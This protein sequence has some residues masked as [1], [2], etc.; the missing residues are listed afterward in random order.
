MKKTSRILSILL[1]LLM[2]F[3][4]PITAFAAG[5]NPLT[6]ESAKVGDV[7][8]ENAKIPAGSD[9]LLTFSNNVTDASVLADNIDKIKVR[10]E[11][12]DEA[13]STVSTGTEKTEFIVTLGDLSKGSYKLTIG[14]GLAAKN[15]NT[16][17]SRI[18]ISFQINKGSGSGTG[19]GNNPL[20]FVS[21]IANDSE[22]EG[23]QLGTNGEIVITFDR[24]MTENQ[25]ANFEQICILDAEGK[26][27]EGVAFTDFTKDG[28]GNSFTVLTYSNLPDGTYT[29]KLGKDLKANNGNTLGEDV[30]IQFTVKGND[31][32]SGILSI[33]KNL[34]N[35]VLDFFG[36]VV[37]FIR[38]LFPKV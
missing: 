37:T 38:G 24:G 7:D 5:D 28:D 10:D 33:L 27:A 36:M 35:K 23:A 14:K 31:K 29:L 19:G 17:T 34:F 26:K 22:L 13:A 8:L 3:S 18:E 20:K 11:A 30:T 4:V 9:I 32:G 6:L 1:A 2:I 12:G 15:G 21:A 25:A 16:L